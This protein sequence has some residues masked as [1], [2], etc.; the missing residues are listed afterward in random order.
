MRVLPLL[1]AHLRWSKEGWGL[2]PFFFLLRF[3]KPVACPCLLCAAM[4]LIAAAV[5]P[6]AVLSL[7]E[8]A[9]GGLAA[10]KIGGLQL[11][12]VRVHQPEKIADFQALHTPPLSRCFS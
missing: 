1:V 7:S 11:N 9:R 2:F 8:L 6:V 4:A 3:R 5:I 10:L 12:R